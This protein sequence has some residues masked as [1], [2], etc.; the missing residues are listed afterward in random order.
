MIEPVPVTVT[1]ARVSSVVARLLVPPLPPG[2]NSVTVPATV[3]ASPALTVGGVWVKTNRPSLVAGSASGSGS[4]NQ[5]PLLLTAVTTPGTL[6]TGLPAS[7]ERC[8]LPWISWMRAFGAGSG[9]GPG[10]EL[11]LLRGFGAATVKSA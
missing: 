1:V 8:A 7:G 11:P 9:P 5:N 4:W 3:T 10:P 6:D 2:R